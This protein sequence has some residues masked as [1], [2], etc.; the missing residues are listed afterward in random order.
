MKIELFTLNGS[1]A[2]SNLAMR[3]LKTALEEAGYTSV[4]C[5]EATLRDRT[6]SVLSRLVAADA[7]LYGFSCYIWNINEMLVLAKDLKTVRPDCKSYS[8]A[9]RF[10]LTPSA[11]PP[12]TLS[13]R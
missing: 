7:S 8:A 13:T 9:P 10:P 3:C 12:L 2:H 5:T 6:A 1:F 4:H 11:L